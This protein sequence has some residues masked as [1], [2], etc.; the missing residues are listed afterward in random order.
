MPILMYDEI[1]FIEAEANLRLGN[2]PE[3]NAAYKE[4]VQ[5]ACSRA[6]LSDDEVAAYIAQGT[7]FTDD[8]SL[9]LDMIMKQKFLSLFMMQPV[10]A[11]NDYR[12]TRYMT[13]YNTQDGFPER[14]V[15]PD[16][17]YAT[18]TNTPDYIDL[19]TIYTE[20]VWWAK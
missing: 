6:G 5:V 12:R 17:E 14:I 9:T 10:E 3:A 4:A 11:Y 18:N 8:E 19:V 1:K 16:D 2:Y 13:L 15:Y 7:V 20:K